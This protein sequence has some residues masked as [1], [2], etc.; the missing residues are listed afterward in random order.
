MK[1]YDLMLFLLGFN[2]FL[3]VFD[4]IGVFGSASPGGRLLSIPGEITI[5]ALAAMIFS[6][7]IT[8]FGTRITRSIVATVSVLSFGYTLLVVRSFQIFYEFKIGNTQLIPSEL[9][10]L[11]VLFNQI[12]FIAALAQIAGGGGWRSSR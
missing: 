3:Y 1:A 2:G 8:I 6:S 5:A 11:F 9:L 12:V 7:A 10:A 4:Q